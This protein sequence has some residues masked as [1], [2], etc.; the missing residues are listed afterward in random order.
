MNSPAV[1]LL[2][3]LWH[4]PLSMTRLARA[5]SSRGFSTANLGYPSPRHEV[6][7]LAQIVWEK[8]QA[9]S[10]V[11][12]PFDFVTHSLGGVLARQLA[13]EHPGLIRRIVM[14][15]P[16]NRGSEWADL[17]ARVPALRSLIG[18]AGC[19]LGT[20]P[21][22]A[23]A[24]LG[25]ASFQAG[26]IAGSKPDNPFSRWVI[27]GPDDGRISVDSTRLDGMADFIALPCGH[28]LMPFSRPVIEQTIHFLRHG[29]FLHQKG[30]RR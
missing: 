20:G 2:H 5:L 11:N 12:P 30:V 10:A 9:L 3:G 8:L 17:A 6:A 27:P 26:V 1:I 25:P 7:R 13:G 19:E 4:S 21:A 28:T 23:P 18:P 15:A 24:R 16:P 14:L 22:G 29:N